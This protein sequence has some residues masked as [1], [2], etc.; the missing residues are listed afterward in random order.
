M[1]AHGTNPRQHEM[2]GRLV[3]A[4]SAALGEPQVLESTLWHQ[5]RWSVER[6]PRPALNIWLTIDPEHAA[7]H[8]LIGDPCRRGGGSVCTLKVRRDEDIGALVEEVRGR[9]RC[10]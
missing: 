1:G 7:P 4:L 2:D 6:R 9:L 5:Y 3:A 8:V 10:E